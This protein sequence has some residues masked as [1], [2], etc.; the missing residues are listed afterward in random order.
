MQV[1]ALHPST[2]SETGIATQYCVYQTIQV[3]QKLSKVW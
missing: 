2:T 3:I 1:M